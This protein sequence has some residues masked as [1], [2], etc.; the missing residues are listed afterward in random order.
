MQFLS[1]LF[2]LPVAFAFDFSE[3]TNK[4]I[5]PNVD[6]CEDFYR[7]A[8]R[9]DDYEWLPYKII[10]ERL[11]SQ[12]ADAKNLN[13]NLQEFEIAN[14][15]RNHKSGYITDTP[16]LVTRIFNDLCV[17]GENTSEF[18]MRIRQVFDVNHECDDG[19]CVAHLFKDPDCERASKHLFTVTSKLIQLPVTQFI[20]QISQIL[21]KVKSMY[22]I[23]NEILSNTDESKVEKL[24]G[25]FLEMKDIAIELIQQTPWTSNH[26]VTELVTFVVEPLKLTSLLESNHNKA[27]NML[28]LF[29]EK[30]VLCKTWC[31]NA[32]ASFASEFCILQTMT[33]TEM[34]PVRFESLN[35][36]IIE[37]YTLYPEISI[38]YVWYYMFLTTENKA[39]QLGAPGF[40]LAHE[41]AHA[42]IK[43][44]EG[45]ILT[46]F[47]EEAKSCIQ[48]QYEKIC[49]EFDEGD[50]EIGSRR[51]EENGADFLAV[52]ILEVLFRRYFVDREKRS[53]EEES[54]K[55]L[56]Q[57]FYSAASG[58]CDGRKR[59][60]IER[61]PH[62]PHNVRINALV[63]HPLFEE[64]FQCSADSRMMRSK[65]KHCSVYGKNAPSNRRFSP[66]LF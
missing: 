6:P 20:R 1:I 27:L 46:Y 37:G 39:A 13:S 8:C 66:K 41:L 60:A 23:T 33:T 25:L 40:T 58:L 63:N 36:I 62:S 29:N 7:H 9:L 19:K 65:T 14:D 48:S 38:G 30:Y 42:I 52:E 17:S 26:N 16:Q 55:D 45:D 10:S 51:F 47:S 12:F 44:S 11:D 15:L 49:E 57:M 43:G 34:K 3:E 61:D 64:A 59:V 54:R 32:T 56:Q 35:D 18:L 2:L 50:C 24:N 31:A 21:D 22:Q 4:R 53:K 5:N 28:K